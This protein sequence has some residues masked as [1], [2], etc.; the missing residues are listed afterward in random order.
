MNPA[1]GFCFLSQ[2]RNKYFFTPIYTKSENPILLF[3]NVHYQSRDKQIY[4]MYKDETSTSR[5]FIFVMFNQY[6]YLLYRDS[7]LYKIGIHCRMS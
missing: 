2:S 4:W 1:T 6:F 5:S 7:K 3:V